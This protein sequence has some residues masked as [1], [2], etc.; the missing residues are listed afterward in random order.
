MSAPLFC[1]DGPA[2]Y[3]P[4]VL[5]CV[6]RPN[7]LDSLA[8][9]NN[10]VILEYLEAG[11]WDWFS[12]NQLRHSGSVTPVVAR[13]E[14]DYLQQIFP[15]E[16]EIHTQMLNDPDEITYR[17]KFHQ[18]ITMRGHDGA[19]L[20]VVKARIIVAFLDMTTRRLYSLQDFF[21]ENRM[22]EAAKREQ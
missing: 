5:R 9:V 3:A 11:R 7:D 20:T 10:A 14:V 22:P 2:N 16:L 17:A 6:T 12:R 15:G 8:H 18:L 13:A 1:D 4:S 19:L 21:E